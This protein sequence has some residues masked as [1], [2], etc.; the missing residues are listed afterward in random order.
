MKWDIWNANCGLLLFMINGISQILKPFL[1]L[2]F[3]FMFGIKQ[4]M[5]FFARLASTRKKIIFVKH[6]FALFLPFDKENCNNI[7]KA[8]LLFLDKCGCKMLYM[9]HLLVICWAEGVPF[10]RGIV[11]VQCDGWNNLDNKFYLGRVSLKNFEKKCTSSPRY[12]YMSI[13]LY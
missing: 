10:M 6:L 7:Q 12:W 3:L 13:G 11:N 1:M 2:F 5:H 4:S 8:I 9:S